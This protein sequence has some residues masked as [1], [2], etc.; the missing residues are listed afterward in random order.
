L[1]MAFWDSKSVTSHLKSFACL[2]YILVCILSTVLSR[3]SIGYEWIKLSLQA[4]A[5]AFI[6]ISKANERPTVIWSLRIAHWYDIPTQP[7]RKLLWPVHLYRPHLPTG[8]FRGLRPTKVKQKLQ[9][10]ECFDQIYLT[11]SLSL[12]SIWRGIDYFHYWIDAKIS[13]QYIWNED[14]SSP[15]IWVVLALDYAVTLETIRSAIVICRATKRSSIAEILCRA[16]FP[17]LLATPLFWA[18]QTHFSPRQSSILR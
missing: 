17:Y 10:W 12:W 8:Q 7:S 18:S 13:S 15:A 6:Q 16:L 3:M 5:T 2:Y 1:N 4:F 9:L 11:D 14:Y